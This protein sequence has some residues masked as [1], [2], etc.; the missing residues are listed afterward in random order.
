MRSIKW[1]AAA[2]ALSVALSGPALA[3]SQQPAAP[4]AQG[5]PRIPTIE[6]LAAH[7][8]MSSFSVS[9]SGR[10]IAAV[11]SEGDTRVVRVWDT[12]NFT[13]EPRT[14]NSTGPQ[15]QGVSFVS[16]GVSRGFASST[17]AAAPDTTAAAMLVPLISM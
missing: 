15:L 16:D 10:Y 11:Q 8:V 14:F 6:Q 4:A 5:Q 9:P 17:S 1:G 12:Q 13:A 3:L 7:P 2:L